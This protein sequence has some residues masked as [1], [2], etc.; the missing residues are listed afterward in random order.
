[1]LLFPVSQ[2]PRKILPD[3]LETCDERGKGGRWKD[4][5]KERRDRRRIG[6]GRGERTKF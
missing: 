1:M 2:P 4:G 3:S 5:R 6:K